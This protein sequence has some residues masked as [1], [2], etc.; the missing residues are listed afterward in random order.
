M[1]LEP[2]ELS[3]CFM[4]EITTNGEY[5]LLICVWITQSGNYSFY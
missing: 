5:V 2:R 3:V 4:L 1:S